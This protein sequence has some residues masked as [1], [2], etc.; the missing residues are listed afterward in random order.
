MDDTW[1]THV[2]ADNPAVRVLA[3]RHASLILGFLHAAFKTK[4]IIVVSH[5]DLVLQLASSLEARGH[6]ESV[7]GD[8]VDRAA[9][10]IDAWCGEQSRYLRKYTDDDGVVQHELTPAMEL[11]L[12]WLDDLQPREFVGTESRFQ[13][14][15]RRIADLAEKSSGDPGKRIADLEQRRAE[16]DAEIEAIRT[17]GQARTFSS[18]QIRERLQE[19][20]RDARALLGDFRQVEE[21]FRDLVREIHREQ[22][23]GQTDRGGILGHTLDMVEALHKAPQGQSFDAFWRF[24][25]ADSGRDEIDALVDQVYRVAGEHSVEGPDALLRRLKHHLHQAG[26]KVVDSNRILAEK[27]SRVL[28][29]RVV[30]E[31]RRTRELIADIKR[32]ALAAVDAP[33]REEAFLAVQGSASLGTVMARPLSLPQKETVFV[34]ADEAEQEMSTAAFGALFSQLAV[35]ERRLRGQIQEMLQGRSQVSLPEVLERFPAREGLAEIVTYVAL[36][37]IVSDSGRDEVTFER[38]D[39]IVRLRIPR[40]IYAL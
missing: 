28:A 34:R 16:I 13:D 21:N 32:L 39:G 31:Q 22:S 33:P 6:D 20:S 14:L 8:V 9:Q 15:L 30:R 3:A 23:E 24:L 10:L 38:D 37:S 35:D 19:I 29:E 18:V 7:D 26:R 2:L 17:T 40:V 11:A 25:V 5:Q 12:R 4:Q 36:A 27:L 1:L